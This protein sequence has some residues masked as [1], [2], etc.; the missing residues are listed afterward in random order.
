[1]F[2]SVKLTKNTDLDKY[3]YSGYGTGFDYHL[4]FSFLSFDWGKNVVIFGVD[5]SFPVHIDYK[6]KHSLV[7]SK[8]PT[9]G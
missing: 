8:G 6:K 9:Q 5:N 3:S 7:L 1:M 4:L 2:G